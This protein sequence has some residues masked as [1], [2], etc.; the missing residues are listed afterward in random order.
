MQDVAE[1]DCDGGGSRLSAPALPA[2][3]KGTPRR[4]S[5]FPSMESALYPPH[6]QARVHRPHRP[7]QQSL[8]A[9][10]LDIYTIIGC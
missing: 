3:M 7:W 4:W 5:F 10:T 6:G 9:F 8:I 2:S 1:G